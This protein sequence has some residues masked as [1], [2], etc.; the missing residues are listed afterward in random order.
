MA[1]TNEV[2]DKIDTFLK[3]KKTSS[4]SGSSKSFIPMKKLINC[5]WVKEEHLRDVA[6]ECLAEIFHGEDE[7]AEE[8]R[9]QMAGKTKEI[10]EGVIKM[11]LTNNSIDMLPPKD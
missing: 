4:T 3:G 1:E 11:Y 2:A 6:L 9:K 10:C 7:M 5:D 8:F